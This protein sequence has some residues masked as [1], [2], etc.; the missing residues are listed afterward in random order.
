MFNSFCATVPELVEGLVAASVL[1][2]IKNEI[3]H[4]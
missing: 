1:S 2:I 4:I 3:T